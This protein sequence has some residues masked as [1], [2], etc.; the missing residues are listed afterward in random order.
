MML[1]VL[2]AESVANGIDVIR[3]FDA[4]NDPRL[5]TAISLPTRKARTCSGLHQ[6][7]P[8]PRAQQRVTL[9]PTAKTLGDGCKLHLHQ[10]HGW[11]AD[12]LYLL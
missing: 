3:I 1:S 2:C 5:Q 7:Y 4:L 9:Q 6:L 10:G 12:S 8:E 11:P